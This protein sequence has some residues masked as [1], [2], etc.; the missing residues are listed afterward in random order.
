MDLIT[1]A[2]GPPATS[3]DPGEYCVN[4]ADQAADARAAWQAKKIAELEKDINQRITELEAKR[5]EYQQWMKQR[6]DILAKADAH[7]VDIYAKMKPDAASQQM[8]ALEDEMAAAVLA[9][10]NAR[11]AS[12]ILNE[13]DPARAAQLTKAMADAARG[14]M[15]EKKS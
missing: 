1:G 6:E 14:I 5:A 4:I 11:T 3:D 12:A 15:Q 13:M 10:L 8:S 7:L 9:K 2:I